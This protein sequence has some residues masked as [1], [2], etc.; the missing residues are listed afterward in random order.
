VAWL[1]VVAL[2]FKI[3]FENQRVTHSPIA[4]WLS[5]AVLSQLP[6]ALLQQ[7]EHWRHLWLLLGLLWGFNCRK[8]LAARQPWAA[9]LY[10]RYAPRRQTMP[11]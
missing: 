2:S 7:V 6:C 11:S 4:T 9:P 3:A 10:A 5:F 8:I 1:L